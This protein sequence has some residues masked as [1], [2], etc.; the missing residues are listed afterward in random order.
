MQAYK[1]LTENAGVS[2][3]KIGDNFIIVEFEDGSRYLYDYMSAGKEHI[4]QMKILAITGQGLT[5]Y[6]NQHVRQHYAEKLI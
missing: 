5:T 2:A 6:I 3:Y 4:E 1:N